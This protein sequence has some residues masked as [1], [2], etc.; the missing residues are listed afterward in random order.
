MSFVWSAAIAVGCLSPFAASAQQVELEIVRAED[1]H[2]ITWNTRVNH[3]YQVYFSDDF[4]TWFDSGILEPGPGTGDPRIT[5]NFGNDAPALFYRVRETED[6]DLGGF[7]VLPSQDQ[8][9]DLIDGVCIAFNLDVLPDLPEK[10]R[11]YTRPYNEVGADWEQIGLITEFAVTSNGVPFVRGSV[12]WIPVSTGEY[13]VRAAAVDDTGGVFAIAT[14]RIN[15]GQNQ[16]PVITITGF[17]PALPQALTTEFEEDPELDLVRRV[18]FYDYDDDNGIYLYLGTDDEYPF[19]DI[20]INRDGYAYPLLD[21]RHEITAKAFDARMGV[22]MTASSYVVQIDSFGNERPSLAITSPSAPMALPQGQPITISYTATDS[23]TDDSITRVQAWDYTIPS[24]G[25]PLAEHVATPSDPIEFPFEPLEISTQNWHPGSCVIRVTA[26]DDLGYRSYPQYVDVTVQDPVAGATFADDLVAVISDENSV[27]PSN[28]SFI[29]VPPSAGVFTDGLATGPE[30]LEFDEGVLITSGAF[31]LWNGGN[32]IGNADERSVEGFFNREEPGDTR[33]WDSVEGDIGTFDAASLNFEIVCS[34]T[35][36]QLEYQFGSEEYP[37]YVGSRNDAFI[38]TIDD[39][40]VSYLPDC[41]DIIA[42]HSV[43]ADTNS[44]LFFA[45]NERGENWVEYNG[46]TTRL[47][48]HALVTPGV[49]HH[50]RIVIADVDD[51]FFDSGLFLG[52]GS[53]RTVSATP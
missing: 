16:P 5:Y 21:G 46:M 24:Q 42:V 7:L 29:G 28:A 35:Q 14:R 23:D 15:V 34:H 39:V 4:Q 17:T 19:G 20:V 31:V 3:N 32:E 2:Q 48:L 22:G 8:T 18:E 43:N 38:V 47:R 12:V 1:G 40:V 9:M 49:V 53:L 27:T 50:V 52:T 51:E 44:H 25:I 10:I 6:L 33:L 13:E 36:L 37:I 45:N 11:I 30:L 41:S 26:T